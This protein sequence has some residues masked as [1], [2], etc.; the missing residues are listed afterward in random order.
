MSSFER[1]GLQPSLPEP[2][3]PLTTLARNL[4]WSWDPVVRRLW[5][6]L[7]PELW[8]A[9]GHNPLE[10]L[11]RLPDDRKAALARDASLAERVAAAARRLEAERRLGDR[12]LDLDFHGRTIAYF[13]AEFGLHES[14]PIYSGGLGVLAG[15]HLKSASDLKL[16]L[17]G[18]GLAYRYGY[19][20]QLL[21]ADGRQ[22][23]QYDRNDFDRL[24][25]ALQTDA[26]GAPL[27]VTVPILDR[28]VTLHV[29]RVAVGTVSLYLLDS[30]VPGNSDEDRLITGHLYGGDMHTRIRQ[31]LVLGVGG[32]RALV[33][34]GIVP[35]VRHMNEGHSAFLALEQI[36]LL[37]TEAGLSLDAALAQAR[38]GNVFTTHTPIPAG[39]DAFPADLLRP[40]L[41]PL[42][43]A[44]DTPVDDLLAL[45]RPA[46]PGGDDGRFEMTILALRAS[47]LANGVSELHGHVSRRM[48]HGLWPDRPV[49]EVPIGHVTNG[50]HL[51]TWQD[52]EL[53]GAGGRPQVP[54]AAALWRRKNVLRAALVSEARRRARARLERLGAGTE[55]LA[56]V[57][58]LL[59]PAVLTVGF[60]RRFAP[61]KRADLLLRDPERLIRLLTHPERPLQIVLAGKAHPRN[62]P[63]KQ[64]LQR[65]WE[66]T[67]R[68]EVRGRFVI[69]ENYDL[70]LG[71]AMVRGCDVWLNTPRRPL[72]A[73]GTSGMKA[74]ANGGLNLSVLD[75]WWREA[76]DPD[77]PNGWGFGEHPD[78]MPADEQDRRDSETLFDLLENAVVPLFYERDADGV[79]SRWLE[80][81]HRA[82]ATAVPR[83]GTDRMLEEYVDRYYLPCLEAD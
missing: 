20:H 51:P 61:Y 55:A 49:D 3:A 44:M 33:R 24:P 65:I 25:M 58:N 67:Q 59:D 79:P 23:E 36:R 39:N 4:R 76:Y 31:E 21:D 22:Q 42:A 52:P 50:V 30:D 68:P 13:C 1:Y 60:A 57:E 54:D 48:W 75:G 46:V 70:A 6:E 16:P 29:W 18:I 71:R 17:V 63:G 9:T 34:L 73:S 40:Y 83:F 78:D 7:D 2:L 8:E 82:A 10:L 19:L 15:D 74:A 27:T 12:P 32:L 69:L 53:A 41:E 5:R 43:A 80:M 81:M 11:D 28:E 62:E 26:A 66:F 72:E 47:R 56:A 35:A 14:L 64:N 38:A 77:R 37:R 45:G